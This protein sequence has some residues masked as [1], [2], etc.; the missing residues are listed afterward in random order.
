MSLDAIMIKPKDNVATAITWGS[1]HDHINRNTSAVMEGV[2][3]LPQY[4][5][6]IYQWKR[7]T[8][9]KYAHRYCNPAPKTATL[10]L[11]PPCN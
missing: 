10:D 9:R 4:G 5:K 3:T 6:P 1:R 8:K 11:T 2:E 7:E